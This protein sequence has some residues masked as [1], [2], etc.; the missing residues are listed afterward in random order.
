MLPEVLD[1]SA[2]FG[3]TSIPEIAAEIPIAGMAGRSASGASGAVLFPRRHDEKHLWHG[4]LYDPQH[5][6]RAGS[7]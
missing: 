1:C 7:L 6:V 4:L 5:R 3:V 2:H